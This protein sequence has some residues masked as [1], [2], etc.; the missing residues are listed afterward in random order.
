MVRL[1]MKACTG[2]KDDSWGRPAAG[3]S[4]RVD[5]VDLM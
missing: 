1:M 5:Q 4:R 3:P 2:G